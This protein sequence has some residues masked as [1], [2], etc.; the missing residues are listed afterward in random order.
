MIFGYNTNV[1]VGAVKYHVQTEDGGVA[2]AVIDTMVYCGGRVLHRRTSNYS[3]LLPLESDRHEAIKKRVDAQ[4]RQVIEEIRTGA[5][6]LPVSVPVVPAAVASSPVAPTL[7]LELVNSKS[8][9]AGKRAT[10]HV[11]VTDSTGNVV[12]AARVTASVSGAAESAEFC[13]ESDNSGDAHLA[14]DLPRLAAPDAALVIE[15]VLGAI[16]G[17]LRFQLRAK[18][19]VP[20][21]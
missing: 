1:S 7:S 5:L 21:N 9:L 3:D 19:R 12:N 2:T 13:A 20:A 8:W 6:V 10:L 18:Q 14:F 17:Q 16:T 15:A 4:H 11:R